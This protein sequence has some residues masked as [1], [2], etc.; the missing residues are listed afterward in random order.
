MTTKTMKARNLAFVL[1]MANGNR[2]L[3]NITMASG[4]GIVEAGTAIGLITASKKF[5]P[6]ADA[7]VVGSEGAEVATAVL[8][9]AVDTTDGDVETVAVDADAEVKGPMLKFDVSVDDETKINAK[10]AQLEAV[11]VRV[12]EGA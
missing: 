1:S 7:E 9:Y 8:A 12:R 11:G 3:A 5:V 10:I 2:S 4:N 6:S